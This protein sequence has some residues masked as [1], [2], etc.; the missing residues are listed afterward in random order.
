M[1]ASAPRTIGYR[2]RSHS[3]IACAP[4]LV[5]NC[6]PVN[7]DLPSLAART[8]VLFA[9]LCAGFVVTGVVV[10][11]AGPALPVFIARW[12][13]TDAQA[14]LFFTAQFLGSLGGVILSSALMSARGF[15]PTLVAGYLLTAT[16]IAALNSPDER[17]ALCAAITF[18][19]GYGFVIPATNLWVAELSGPRR[20]ALLNLLNLAWGAGAVVCPLL[21]YR[22]ARTGHFA[23]L[24]FEIAAAS[25]ALGAILALAPFESRAPAATEDTPDEATLGFAGIRTAI[26]LAFLF[27]SYV[28][29]ESGISGWAAAHA[30]RVG[31]ASGMNW[32]LAPVFFWA[33][34]L[35]GRGIAS[36]ILLRVRESRL[37]AGGL[38]LAAAGTAVLLSARTPLA[39]IA[40][41]IAA[42]LGLS[43]LYPIFIAWLSKGYG[44][45]ARSVGGGLFALAALGG[46]VMPWLVGQLSSHG[47]GL[48][49]GLFVPFAGCLAM[50]ALVGLVGREIRS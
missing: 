40:G 25:A 33:A 18:G 27:F 14:G 1:L 34:L 10:T 32:A 7:T 15:R 4:G 21:V 9:I 37:V 29:T 35:A 42:G 3:N 20:S 47:G 2:I 31:S 46:A 38:L 48:R 6:G 13:L 19:C 39:V 36:L 26:V 43:S 49:A 28:G 45:R 44:V 17:F 8:S 22:A 41:V 5:H 50:L 11:L 23:Q 16:G 12:S 30:K 24:L